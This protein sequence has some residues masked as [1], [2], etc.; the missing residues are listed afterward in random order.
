[1]LEK[2]MRKKKLII[3]GVQEGHDETDQEMEETVCGLIN[4]L[5][6]IIENE[7]DIA[8]MRRIGKEEIIKDLCY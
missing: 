6:I 1:M 2:E 5:Q 7:K 3:Q 8:E 4:M